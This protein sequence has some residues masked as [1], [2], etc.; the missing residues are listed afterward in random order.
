MNQYINFFISHW[1]LSALFLALLVALIISEWLNRDS[2]GS[3]VS[4]ETAVHLMNHQEALV[5][6][7][8]S[9]SAFSQGH[10]LGAQH[11]T[12]QSLEKKIESMHKHKGKPII[13]VNSE[14]DTNPKVQSLLRQ[15]G[16]QVLVLAGGIPGWRSAGLPLVKKD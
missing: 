5:F 12:L 9:E 10:I 1:F 7:F 2:G 14:K 4:P 3:R 11:F 6:D 15:K 16:F 8:R 13:L